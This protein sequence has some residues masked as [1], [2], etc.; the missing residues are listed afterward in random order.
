MPLTNLQFPIEKT[1]KSD[2][3]D[4]TMVDIH[5]QAGH[6]LENNSEFKKLIEYILMKSYSFSKS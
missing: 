6:F 1:I 2:G 3:D 4:M 5:F